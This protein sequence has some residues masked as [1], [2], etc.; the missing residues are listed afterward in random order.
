MDVYARQNQRYE[1]VEKD[2]DYED[3]GDDYDWSS[4]SIILP[5]GKD[6]KKWLQESIKENEEQETETV[7]LELPQVSPL[8]LNENQR[9]IVSLV[10]YTLY[11]C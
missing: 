8:S 3:G 10:L 7:D 5:E 11:N 1:G 6:P 9:A 2:L 4:P